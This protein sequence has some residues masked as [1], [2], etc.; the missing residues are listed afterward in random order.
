MTGENVTKT[1]GKLCVEIHKRVDERLD[2]IDI[3]IEK[4][5]VA[6]EKLTAASVDH[7]AM[8][9]VLLEERTTQMTRATA[10]AEAPAKKENFWN[11]KAGGLAVKLI[12][13]F[14]VIVVLG[15][16]G[17]NLIEGWQ[18]VVD[19]IPGVK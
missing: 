16:L 10:I 18:T 17:V 5:V 13:A 15:M 6:I 12:F 11:T 3:Y 8:L 9:R 19:K 2:Y 1:G 7:S 4:N 14:L